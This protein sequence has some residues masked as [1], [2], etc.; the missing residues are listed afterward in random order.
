MQATTT[1]V[2]LLDLNAQYAPIV[3]PVLGAIAKVFASKQF[4]LGPQVASFESKVKEYL[5]VPYAL[6][7]SSGTDAILLALM[8]MG[9]GAGDEV[10]VPTFTFFA[11]AGCVA[12]VGAT[13][14]FV[15]IDPETFNMDPKSVEAAIT[16]KTKAIMP[17]HLFGQMADMPAIMAIAERHNIWVIEDAS[18]S[19]GCYYELP[20]DPT[21]HW[22]GAVGDVACFSFFPSKN[23]GCIGDGGLVTT[24]HPELAEKM[25][26]M[27]NHGAKERYY[28]DEVG[29]NFRLDSIQAAVLEV[30]LPYLEE[31]HQARQAHGE[32]YTQ[33]LQDVVRTPIVRPG[34][35]MIYNQYTLRTSQRAELQHYLN[36]RQIGNAIYYPL[37]LHEQACFAQLGYQKGQFPHAEQAA[38]EVLS[39]P[40]YA[41]LTDGQRETVALSI[42]EF[43]GH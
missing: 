43:F 1:T 7:V 37:C 40:V 9:I 27:R 11:T 19:I 21:Q 17:V 26:L 15:D 4:I 42:R 2:P 30:K 14:V 38:Q 20:G 5:R 12:R 3:E 29:G 10:I 41:E 25:Q 13:P 16:E 24:R 36:S 18:Q 22:S 34:Y 6:G 31:Q 33:A 35:R 8:A 32:F 39:I 23:L 28:H